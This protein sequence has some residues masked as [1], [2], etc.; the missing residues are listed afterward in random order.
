MAPSHAIRWP[1]P[2]GPGSIIID[3]PTPKGAQPADPASISLAIPIDRK[4]HGRRLCGWM[5]RNRRRRADGG[6]L[7]AA[8]EFFARSVVRQRNGE[9]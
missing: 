5:R 9:T 4:G 6:W 1:G 7:F 3:G 8:R 2:R